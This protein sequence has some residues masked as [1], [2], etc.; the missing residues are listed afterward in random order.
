[1]PEEQKYKATRSLRNE[2]N[3]LPKE[4][5]IVPPPGGWKEHTVY[6]VR[7]SWSPHNPTYRALFHVGFLPEPG[8]FGGYCQVWNHSMQP[9]DAHHAFYLEAEE[10]LTTLKQ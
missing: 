4:K 1:M 9:T 3:H 10:E 6:V 5:A 8:R 7:V 2:I